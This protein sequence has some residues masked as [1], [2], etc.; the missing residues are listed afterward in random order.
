MSNPIP[1]LQREQVKRRE[2]G[3]CFRCGGPAQRGHWHHRR[4]R[5]VPGQHQHCAC[6]GVWLCGTCHEWAHAHPFEAKAE[7]I[8]VS[9]YVEEPGTVVAQAYYGPILLN[10]AG[11]F[12]LPPEV[13]EEK[14]GEVRELGRAADD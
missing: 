14:D 5:S 3:R 2:V 11:S 9:R 7:G 10:C 4:S 8:I 1:P 12:E 13:E 6:N